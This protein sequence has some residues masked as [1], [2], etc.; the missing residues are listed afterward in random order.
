METTN[1]YN[2]IF[3]RRLKQARLASGLSQKRLGI[4]AGIDEFVA[5][6]RIN[7]YEKGVHEPNT[8]IVRRLSEVLRV[9]LAY[10]YAEDDDL[11]ELMLIFLSLSSKQ[12]EE[13]MDYARLRAAS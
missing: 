11:A 5:S 6:T 8:D 4:A 13:L 1:H 9:P 7:R 2:D 12:R 3:C 10:F